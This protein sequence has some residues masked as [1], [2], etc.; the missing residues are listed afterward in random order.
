VAV[1]VSRGIPLHEVSLL[2]C[3][4]RLTGSKV[5]SETIIGFTAPDVSGVVTLST[6][7]NQSGAALSSYRNMTAGFQRNDVNINITC[8]RTKYL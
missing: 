4:I 8:G 7:A 5:C 6:K 2:A 1:S 3:T